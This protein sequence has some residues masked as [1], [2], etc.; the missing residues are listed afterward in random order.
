MYIR[1]ADSILSS[2]YNHV[3]PFEYFQVLIGEISEP[4][5]RG[6]FSGVPFAS[7][8]FG[9]LLVYALGTF[10]PW[11]Y[12]AGLSTILPIT[13]LVL[14]CFLPESPLWLTRNG[15]TDKAKK[16]LIWLRGGDKDKV[17]SLSTYPYY[18]P[19]KI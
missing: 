16:A 17:S 3:S 11:R 14:L 18:P 5:L 19:Q 2:S 7:Y 8:S 15:K 13:A 10:S 12:V 9:I 4:H 6:M 1:I